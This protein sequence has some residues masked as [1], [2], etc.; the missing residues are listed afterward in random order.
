MS[1]EQRISSTGVLVEPDSGKHSTSTPEEEILGKFDEFVKKHQL[2]ND[3]EAQQLREAIA[4]RICTPSHFSLVVPQIGE[5]LSSLA[6]VLR[7]GDAETIC[8][9]EE[10][11]RLLRGEIS[12]LVEKHE[13]DVLALR[14][15]IEGLK[16]FNEDLSESNKEFRSMVGSEK[17][18]IREAADR[19]ARLE[20]GSLAYHFDFL[21]RK[22]LKLPEG[23]LALSL[24]THLSLSELQKLIFR[25][26]WR[27]FADNSEQQSFLHLEQERVKKGYDELRARWKFRPQHENILRGMKANRLDDAHPK[28]DLQNSKQ[29]QALLETLKIQFA[30]HPALAEDLLRFTHELQTSV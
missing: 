21:L 28:L 2:D 7:G 8:R 5:G 4:I 6:S 16:L 18:Q 3:P 15:E 29:Y 25:Q 1:I 17:E 22:K 24:N 23:D 9:L 19:R 13:S 20:V 14:S 10:E 12:R 11:I 26:D 30:D 27:D